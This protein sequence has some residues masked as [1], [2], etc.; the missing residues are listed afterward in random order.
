MKNLSTLN[1]ELVQNCKDLIQKDLGKEILH[2]QT[3]AAEDAISLV[4]SWFKLPWATH[5]ATNRC[6]GEWTTTKGHEI[7]WNDDM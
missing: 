7:E 2:V 5:R 3:K 1:L 6:K 4:K